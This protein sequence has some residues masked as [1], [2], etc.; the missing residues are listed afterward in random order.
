M[1][2]NKDLETILDACLSQIEDGYS[3]IDECLAHYPEHAE[4]LSPLLRAAT[5]L[6]RGREVVPDAAYKARARTQLNI[7]MQQYP[8][9]RRI[10]P[11][12][13]RFSISFVTV[14]LLF[15]ASGTA[16][17]QRALPGDPLYRWKLTSEYVWRMS[18]DDQL[19]VDLTLS[20]RRMNELVVVSSDEFRRAHVVKNY[21]QL[22]IKFNAEQ[23]SEKQERI[24][25]ILRAQH[26][27]LVKSG[28]SVP[29]LEIYF[30]R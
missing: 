24:L 22:L 16:F 18:S 20:N 13:W 10:S 7:Y 6:A 19:G 12:L 14:L 1:N 26:E 5:K 28:V 15:L 17:A 23:D 8:Q 11:V 9:R 25:P 2:N 27:W 30:P 3:S 29:E 21:E 4:Q